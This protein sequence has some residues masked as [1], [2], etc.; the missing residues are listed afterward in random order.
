VNLLAR[1]L[2]SVRGRAHWT[3]VHW[4]PNALARY[5]GF[6]MK[7]VTTDNESD[8]RERTFPIGSLGYTGSYRER[9]EHVAEVSVVDVLEAR[10]P[11]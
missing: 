6:L 7:N 4:W 2:V 9:S 11:D 1:S 3:L 10:G 5:G 8:W